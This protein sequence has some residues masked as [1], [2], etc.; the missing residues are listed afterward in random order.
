MCTTF[1]CTRSLTISPGV[2]EGDF[3]NAEKYYKNALS[4]PMYATLDAAQ[5]A[6]VVDALKRALAA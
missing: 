6:T 4:L 5:Q 3:P 1:L 2:H